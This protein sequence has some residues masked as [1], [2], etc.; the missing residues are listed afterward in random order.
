[1]HI[2]NRL[3]DSL[4]NEPFNSYGA[5]QKADSARITAIGRRE[6]PDNQKFTASEGAKIRLTNLQK[7]IIAGAADSR[8]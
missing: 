1:M 2:S 8:N 5:I 6:M 3:G 4:A 7:R